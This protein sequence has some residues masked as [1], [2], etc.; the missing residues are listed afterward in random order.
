MPGITASL[1]PRR[2]RQV[3]LASLRWRRR[4]VFI[5]GGIAVGA[6]AVGLAYA[7]DWMSGLFQAA[8]APRPLLVLALTPGGF[9]LCRWL[10]IRYVPNAGGSGIP[11]AIAARQLQG[12]VARERLVSL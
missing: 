1:T 10:A 7:A 9:A 6:A 5:L 2:V 4:A 11:Q 3:R 8:T 12:R